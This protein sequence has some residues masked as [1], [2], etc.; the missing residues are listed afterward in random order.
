V[1]VPPINS[2]GLRVLSLALFTRDLISEEIWVND[3]ESDDFT[4]GV[5]SPSPMSTAKLR[6]YKEE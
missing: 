3:F 2:S 5:I 6:S 4:I 1:K